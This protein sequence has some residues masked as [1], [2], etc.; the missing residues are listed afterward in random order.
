MPLDSVFILLLKT[1]MA[2]H[3][4]LLE[5]AFSSV[6]LTNVNYAYSKNLIILLMV[7]FRN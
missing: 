7:I 4:E 5:M 6:V 2:V 3:L 1:K